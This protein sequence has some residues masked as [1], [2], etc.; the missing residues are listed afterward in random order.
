MSAPA[1][2]E[3]R[4]TKPPQRLPIVILIAVLI[5]AVV[6]ICAVLG[7]GI[8]PYSPFLQRLGVFIPIWP[9]DPRTTLLPPGNWRSLRRRR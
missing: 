4:K 5:I 6:V 1:I 3:T 8:A 9:N 7:E 2:N